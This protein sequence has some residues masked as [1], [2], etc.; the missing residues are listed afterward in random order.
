MQNKVAIVGSVGP[1]NNEKIEK[2]VLGALHIKMMLGIFVLF[3]ALK[4]EESMLFIA[5]LFCYT[6][7]K[8]Q[9]YK[10]PT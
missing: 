8:K 3:Y 4:L 5:E 10:S 6:Q 1:C 7:R 2:E 9:W